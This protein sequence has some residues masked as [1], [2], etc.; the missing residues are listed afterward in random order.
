MQDSCGKLTFRTYP[1]KSEVVHTDKFEI[2]TRVFE[3]CLYT[4]CDAVDYELIY[5]T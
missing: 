3:L 4:Y 2:V 1:L 5:G